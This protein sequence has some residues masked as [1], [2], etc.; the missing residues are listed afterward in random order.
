MF[1]R[2]GAGGRSALYRVALTG[3]EPQQM[4]IPQDGSDPDWSGAID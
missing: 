1:A 2:L 3:G 4:K